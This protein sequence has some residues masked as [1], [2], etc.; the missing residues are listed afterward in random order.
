MNIG[1][2]YIKDDKG[3]E[4]LLEQTVSH[5]TGDRGRDS[6]GIELRQAK[7]MHATVKTVPA[8]AQTKSTKKGDK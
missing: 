6:N 4:K 2:S 1:G 7:K 5:K 8:K 3:N